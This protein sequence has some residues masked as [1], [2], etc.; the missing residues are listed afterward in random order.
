MAG[1]GSI[2]G[3]GKVKALAEDREP[4]E[5]QPRESRLWFNRFE[6]F[7]NLGPERKI[8]D[9][10]AVFFPTKKKIMAS[11]FYKKA[12][13]WQW[14]ERAEAWDLILERQKRLAELEEV[15][16]MS[17]RHARESMAIQQS[18]MIPVQTII[19]KM[20]EDPVKVMKQM[21][22][23]GMLELFNAV[24]KAS[25]VYPGMAK[26]ERLARGVSSETY[27]VG[28]DVEGHVEHSVVVYLP[29]NGRD[30]GEALD[31]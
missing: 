3:T 21:E 22:E 26:I 23:L 31:S 25:T 4:W 1:G 12:K 8:S 10:F 29:D 27:D 9:T 5:R 14:R 30:S 17:A 7:R 18:L 11:P 24:A 15:K 6:H 19:R 28:L 20:K 16:A 2:G 13:E